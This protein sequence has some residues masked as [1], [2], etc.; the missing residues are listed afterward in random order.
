MDLSE[1][2][3]EPEKPKVD[4]GPAAAAMAL[5][6]PT[7]VFELALYIR[8]H[9]ISYCGTIPWM[10]ARM[11]TGDRRFSED[12]VEWAT[13]TAIGMLSEGETR[14]GIDNGVNDASPLPS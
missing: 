11:D 14:E 3:G 8:D 6:K 9:L 4:L 1:S 13:A 2:M 7:G 5:P 10:V 12:E